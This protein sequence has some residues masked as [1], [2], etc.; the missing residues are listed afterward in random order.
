M[1][2]ATQAST[3]NR[4]AA[5]R[6]I[7]WVAK[8]WPRARVAHEGMMLD[9]M[10]RQNR[11]VEVAARNSMTG[12]MSD[13]D[14]WPGGEGDDGM[15]VS[16]GDNIHH[17]YAPQPSEPAQSNAASP[18]TPSASKWM[19]TALLAMALLSGPALLAMALLSGTVGVGLAY[20]LANQNQPEAI[21]PQNVE[22]PWHLLPGF[23]VHP[24][25]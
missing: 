4:S 5:Q 8:H 11:I 15:G 23:E 7:D 22:I 25:E 18:S 12:N 24:P 2:D 19:K 21:E 10:Q 16:I 20:Y 3:C 17:H 1:S 14:G 9:K 13:L 6:G